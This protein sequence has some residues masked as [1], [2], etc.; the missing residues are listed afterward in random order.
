MLTKFALLPKFLSKYKGT[1]PNWGYGSLSYFTFMRTYS[2][3]LPTGAKEE[4]FDTVK[5]VVEGV[6][7][8]QLSHC[9]KLKLPWDIAKSQKSAQKM[10]ELIWNFKFTPPGR[11]FWIMGTPAATEG[12]EHF[13]GG[14][15]L[16]NC[17]F[18]STRYIK[19]DFGDPFAWTCDMLMLG[20]GIGFDTLGAGELIITPPNPLTA[21]E[22]TIEDS[23]EGWV[24]AIRILLNSYQGNKAYVNFKY[25][26]IRG[27]GEKIKGFGGIASGP[28]PL[29]E[30]LENIRKLL[31]THSGMYVTS[32]L[33]TDIMNYI[34]KFVVSGNVRRSAELSIGNINDMDFINMKNPLEF[35]TELIDRRWASNNSV[36]ATPENDFSHIVK[37]IISGGDTGI[38]LMDNARHYGRYKDGYLEKNDDKFDDASGVNPCAEQILHHKELCN[39]V[40][41]YPA[42]HDSL[43]EYLET[44]KYAYLYA[45]TVTLV[46]THDM[47]TN[48]VMMR[49]RRIGISQSGIQQA[50]K[51][52]GHRHYF[53]SFC[54]QGYKTVKYWDRIY[55]RWLGIPTSIRMS[56]VKPSG[57][58]S[59]LAGATPG[60]HWTHS[61]Y[62]YRTIRIAGNSPLVDNLIKASYKLEVDITHNY[63]LDAGIDQILDWKDLTK[64]QKKVVKNL[65]ITLVAYFPVKENNFT[66]SKSEISIWEQMSLVREMQHYWSDNSVSVTINVK[67]SEYNDLDAAIKFFTPY[68]KT[69]SF[70][71]LND[72]RYKQ[73]PYIEITKEE[74]ETY[75]NSLKELDLRNTAIESLGEKYCTNDTC[76][77]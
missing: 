20:V 38:I 57:T 11:G 54:D 60:V 46:P 48:S 72:H 40:E 51:K 39:I 5:R 6:Y 74:Y 67:K 28:K 27:A 4:Y 77:I 65:G 14:A 30:G 66:K 43:E 56:T 61:E 37:N 16:T 34:G 52:F 53:N 9:N 62:Y 31:N 50:I 32:V 8:I 24:E 17:G 36:F 69:L 13:K 12:S 1:Q 19:E 33:I 3:E 25:D 49:N 55:S 68:V 73:A 64:D 35:M 29:E 75:S 71:L 76:Q 18:V 23:R 58:V 21:Y 42:N 2:R 47:E 70:L 15:V 22:H 63:K 44:L 59:L 41:T 10:F 7:Q 45:K 26:K